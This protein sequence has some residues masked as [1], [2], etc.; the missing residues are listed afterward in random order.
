M[1]ILIEAVYNE[2]GI[3]EAVRVEVNFTSIPNFG[4]VFIVPCYEEPYKAITFDL[5]NYED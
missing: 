2:D 5:R 1:K 3:C 4:P